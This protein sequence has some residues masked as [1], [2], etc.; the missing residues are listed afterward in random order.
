MIHHCISV[1]VTTPPTILTGYGLSPTC[2]FVGTLVFFLIILLPRHRTRRW[3]SG[4][5]FKCNACL[6][7]PCIY[8]HGYSSFQNHSDIK[9]N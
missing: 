9:A 6:P 5:N 7:L 8:S 4:F 2:A 3:D 1:V